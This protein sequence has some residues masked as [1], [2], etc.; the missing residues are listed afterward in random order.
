MRDA[1]RFDVSVRGDRCPYNGQ[2]DVR[3]STRNKGFCGDERSFS[4]RPSD[5]EFGGEKCILK[6]VSLPVP[7]D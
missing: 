5:R 7:A 1:G 4:S 6:L 2:V 3:V